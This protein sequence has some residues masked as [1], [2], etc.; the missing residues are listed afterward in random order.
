VDLPPC[1]AGLDSWRQVLVIPAFRESGRLLERLRALPAGAGRTLV[2]LV[3]NT[4]DRHPDPDA[5]GELR[6]AVADLPPAQWPLLAALNPTT[7][8][9]LHDLDILAGPLPPAQGVG[10]ARK[11]GCDIAFRW[12]SEGGIG[13]RWICNS[14][15]DALL[16]ADYFSRLDTIPADSAGAVFPFRHAP[17]ADPRCNRATALYE[18]R[19]HHY[20]LG[21][22]YAGSPYAYHTLGSCLA[23]SF[24]GYARVRGFPRRS[25]AED[26]YLLNKLAKLAPVHR[27][28]GECI[29]L[30]SRE[31][32]RVPFGTGPAVAAIL[33]AE[34]PLELPLFYH[35]AVFD[36]LR[37]LLS[38]LPSLRVAQADLEQNLRAHGLEPS[39]ATASCAQLTTMD[40]ATALA[41][42]RRQ[43]KT[44][45]Q[46]MRQFH[47]WFDGFR[48]LKFIHG[49]RDAGWRLQTTAN[50]L[51]RPPVFWPEL[52][53]ADESPLNETLAGHWGWTRRA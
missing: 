7:D 1:P 12:M 16:P 13:G 35:P 3:L 19:L 52:P 28:D 41:H 24:D 14:D 34:D 48:T 15:A 33:R 53:V 17:G 6:A 46:F 9:Y 5:N 36:A 45:E 26:F 2:I 32:S 8:L 42:C 4:P 23:V 39:L 47:Q 22:E 43:G 44:P 27:L 40:F 11:I 50:L 10:L 51:G 37:A 21:L 18:A 25:G 20:V 30:D 29:A 49:L 38:A 31:S